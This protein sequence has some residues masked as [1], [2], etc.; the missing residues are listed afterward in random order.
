MCEI[1]LLFFLWVG[2]SLCFLKSYVFAKMTFQKG[3]SLWIFRDPTWFA[4]FHF[5]LVTSAGSVPAG[6][7]EDSLSRITRGGFWGGQLRLVLVPQLDGAGRFCK[8]QRSLGQAAGATFRCVW[9][10]GTRSTGQRAF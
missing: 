2:L 4:I 6:A 8:E 9:Q 10:A 7:E 3:F 5:L 1:A